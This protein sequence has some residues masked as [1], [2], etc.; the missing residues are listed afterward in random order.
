MGSSSWG[1][2]GSRGCL[3]IDLQV[4]VA[5]LRLKLPVESLQDVGARVQGQDALDVQAAV[6]AHS[7][8]PRMGRAG[9][10]VACAYDV[11]GHQVRQAERGPRVPV[12]GK[13]LPRKPLDGQGDVV[14]LGWPGGL[15]GDGDLGPRAQEGS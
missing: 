9:G 14:P 3:T 2:G 7:L 8:P 13:Q 15:G 6:R 11:A 5:H 1:R 4:S 12:V 10:L